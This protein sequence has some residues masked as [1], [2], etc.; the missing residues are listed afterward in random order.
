MRGFLTRNWNGICKVGCAATC[1][2]VAAGCERTSPPHEGP[3]VLVITLDTTRADRLSCY[4]YRAPTSENLDRLADQ[5]VLFTRAIAQAAVTPVSHASIFTGQNPYTHGLRVMHGLQQN[6]LRESCATLAEVLRDVGYRTAAFV[7]AFPVTQRFGLDQ[8][9]ETFDAEFMI[10][11]PE[12][13]V[14]D[15]GVVNTVDFLTLLGN[16]G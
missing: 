2:L 12:T 15:D 3:S 1:L 11:S 5:G 6:R 14:S 8:G 4:G 13:L 9:F 10:D 7:S 16:W